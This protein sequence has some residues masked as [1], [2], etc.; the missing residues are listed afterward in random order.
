MR[1]SGARN[2]EVTFTAG[3]LTHF[4]GVYLLH[5]FLQ[6][7]QFRTWLSRHLQLAERNN[8]FSVTERIS[9]LTYPMILGLN[10][11]E[12]AALLGTNGV[13]QYIT[14]LPRFPNPSTLRRFLIDKAPIL[15]PRLQR[16]HVATLSQS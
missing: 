9:A 5:R 12:L 6:Q 13:F 16:A 4:G 14:G 3:Q 8:D 7:L 15:L 2:I 1:R 10:T 11:I